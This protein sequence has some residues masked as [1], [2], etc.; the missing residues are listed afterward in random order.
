MGRDRNIM[1]RDETETGQFKTR[2]NE[3]WVP[4]KYPNRDIFET[5][6][7]SVQSYRDKSRR[8]KFGT[9]RDETAFLVSS[10]REISRFRFLDP[11]LAFEFKKFVTNV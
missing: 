5:F 9:G 10:R 4:S 6:D 7:L 8:D 1:G 3:K 2:H 11:S